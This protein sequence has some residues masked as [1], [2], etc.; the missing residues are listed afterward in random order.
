MATD[1]LV[2]YMMQ[3]LGL[4]LIGLAIAIPFV[5]WRLVLGNAFARAG[6][7]P[8]VVA[9]TCVAFG[10]LVANLMSSYLDFSRRVSI[11]LLEESQRWSLI[12][13]WTIYGAV[14]SLIFLLPLLA[15]VGVPLCALLLRMQR[16]TYVNIAVAAIALWLLLALVGWAVPR[17]SVSFTGWLIE[18]LPSIVLIVVPFFVGVRGSLPSPR[19]AGN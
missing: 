14:I 12:P 4:T 5:F 6:F 16:L 3:P 11:G 2:Y 13:G 18:L 8:L 15:I 7:T 17:N 10:L 9:Y 1:W 19:R